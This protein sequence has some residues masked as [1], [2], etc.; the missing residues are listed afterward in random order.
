MRM[1]RWIKLPKEEAERLE[2]EGKEAQGA[3]YTYLS[4]DNIPMVEFHFDD[5]REF[6]ERLRH[7]QTIFYDKQMMGRS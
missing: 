5:S 4:S 7:F 2:Q 1:H 3:G 6:T